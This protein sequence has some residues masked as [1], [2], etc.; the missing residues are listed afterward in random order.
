MCRHLGYL[1][2]PRT[3]QELVLD[4]PYSLG[5]QAYAPRR[6][7]H[8]T[9]NVDGFGVGWYTSR[10]PEPVRYRR[11]QPM[12]ADQSFASLAPTVDAG[13]VVAAVRS[14]TPG[15][16]SEES[17]AA[18]FTHGHW[19]FSHNGA[20]GDLALARKALRDE[21][22]WV[23]DALAPVDSALLFGLALARW[24]GGSSL[25]EGLA[26]VTR[27]VAELGGGRLNL[28]AGDGDRIAGTTYGDTLF[29]HESADGV[30]LASEPCDDDPA[31]APVPPRSLVEVD[32][33]GVVVTSL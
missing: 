6:Q 11:A 18:P 27:E 4:P 16:P 26:R 7:E 9:I 1:G 22:A 2:R 28:L 5:V 31:W 10:R 25:G 33:H 32:R 19:L 20:L 24:E 30:R 3:L 23:P 8:G 21:V 15:Y 17:G 13:C 14:A 29:V 12:W